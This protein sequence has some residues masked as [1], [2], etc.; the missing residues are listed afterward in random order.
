MTGMD[1]PEVESLRAA[2]IRAQ[3]GCAGSPRRSTSEGVR[4]FLDESV[5][6]FGI[7]FEESERL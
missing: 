7:G 1:G 6:P 2:H 4:G 5:A 3:R